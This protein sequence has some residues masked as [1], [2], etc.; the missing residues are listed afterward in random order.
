MFCDC[1]GK[2]L[3]WMKLVA[4]GGVVSFLLMIAGMPI[5]KPRLVLFPLPWILGI[6]MLFLS[7]TVPFY[8][9]KHTCREEKK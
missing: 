7:L 1:W 2:N 4:A 5:F 3:F 8:L 9:M 6:L